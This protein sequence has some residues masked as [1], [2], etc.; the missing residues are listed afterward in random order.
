M[1][2]SPASSRSSRPPVFGRVGTAM[3]TPFAE[4][5]SL[6]LDGAQK[7][8]RHLVETGTDTVV[9]AGTTGESPTLH[10]E[11]TWDLL[12]VV[13]EAVGDD[14]MVIV[15]TGSNDT[16]HALE[17]TERANAAGVDG[18][19]VVTPYYNKPDARGQLRH[20][21][22]LAEATASKVLLYDIIGRTGVEI[23][24]AVLVELAGIENV[25]GVKDAS[26]GVVKAGRLLAVTADAPGGFQVYSGAD[27][28]NLPLAA[29]GSVG[30]VSVASHLAGPAIAEMYDVADTDLR[31]AG[32]IHRALLPL[33]DAL[34]SAPSPSPLKGALA[35]FGL[36]A[37]PVR[38]PLAPATDEVV[39]AVLD[40]LDHLEQ[41]MDRSTT[42]DVRS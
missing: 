29:V 33:V 20:F 23:P 36:P 27:E 1:A 30:A 4:D 19:L 17:S 13:Q 24:D 40:A 26:G 37:G 11:E 35:R 21:T 31:R 10:G 15:G 2:I 32:E 42:T 5:G 39:R 38:L 22:A 9:V 34:F 16:R 3:V 14:A 25:V 28:H 18:V 12:R 6:D 8:A 41:V 7:L